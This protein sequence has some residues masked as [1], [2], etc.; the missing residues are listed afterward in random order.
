MEDSSED[1]ARRADSEYKRYHT[2]YECDYG[3]QTAELL[4]ICLG[5]ERLEVNVVDGVRSD[6][7]QA[8]VHRGH[9][10]RENRCDHQPGD[11]RG[12]ILQDDRE[13]ESKPSAHPGKALS[14]HTY[15]DRL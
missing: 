14:V 12:H 15:N 7:E 3:G 11:D 6:I 9:D 4:F 1:M 13:E 10:R 5:V 2:G 8:Y